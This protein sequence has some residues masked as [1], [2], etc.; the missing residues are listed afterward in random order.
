[1]LP[2]GGI[3]VGLYS[4]HSLNTADKKSEAK[5]VSLVSNMQQTFVAFFGFTLVSRFKQR[6]GML[7]NQKWWNIFCILISQDFTTSTPNP[8]EML[9]GTK[10]YPGQD[11]KN[12]EIKNENMSRSWSTEQGDRGQSGIPLQAAS[13]RWGEGWHQKMKN[14][15]WT[16]FSNF[17]AVPCLIPRMC[18]RRIITRQSREGKPHR[19]P[20]NISDM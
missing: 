12:D 1:M 18:L 17:Q 2:D 5:N 9:D 4:V 13:V 8:E 7:W 11:Q 16:M 20:H 6:K 10:T 19:D 15:H 3:W 14:I